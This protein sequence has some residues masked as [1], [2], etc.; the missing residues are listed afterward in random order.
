VGLSPKSEVR[1]P[2]AIRSPKPKEQILCGTAAHFSERPPRTVRISDFGLLSDF[3]DSN[4]GFR[5]KFNIVRAV[6]T[7]AE[8]C[9]KAWHIEGAYDTLVEIE[10]SPWVEEM[11]ADTTEQWRNKWEMH[12]CMIYL[13]SVGCFEVI[14][15]SWAAL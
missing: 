11:R 10:G 13:D 15:E 8:R 1:N 12:H 5:V 6:R 2:K 3:A 9:C 4:F 7:R 14:A